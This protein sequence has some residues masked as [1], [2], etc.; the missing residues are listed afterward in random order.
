MTENVNIILSFL[1]IFLHAE[2]EWPETLLIHVGWFSWS[3]PSQYQNQCWRFVSRTIGNKIPWNVN[4]YVT[5]FVHEK[6]LE[7]VVGEVAA[8]LSW[9]QHVDFYNLY[10]L[11]HADGS[12]FSSNTILFAWYDN[13]ISVSD[14]KMIHGFYKLM[15]MFLFNPLKKQYGRSHAGESWCMSVA[16]PGA[17][18]N[19]RNFN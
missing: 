7:N 13:T 9:F 3:P 5:F 18:I 2:K 8:T 19:L 10:P 16:S 12:D 14:N 4:P 15:I 6:A 1:Q 17:Y 11:N